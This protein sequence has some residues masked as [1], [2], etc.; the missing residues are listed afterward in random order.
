[1]SHGKNLGTTFH[2]VLGRIC[3]MRFV[4]ICRRPAPK[5]GVQERL[6]TCPPLSRPQCTFARERMPR[7]LSRSHSHHPLHFASQVK[8][9]VIHK[10]LSR[11]KN[12]SLV[13]SRLA[14]AETFARSNSG[15]SSSGWDVINC[16]SPLQEGFLNP[17]VS[18]RPLIAHHGACNLRVFQCP[19]LNH[20]V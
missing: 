4:K 3:R 16:P 2:L 17:V 1:M 10:F 20:S 19:W 11:G 9:F 14:A 18:A 7:L 6:Q 13:P 5:I 15:N 8:H 12:K